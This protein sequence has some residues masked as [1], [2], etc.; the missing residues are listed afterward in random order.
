MFSVLIRVA[1]TAQAANNTLASVA[2]LHVMGSYGSFLIISSV[3][4]RDRRSD[5]RSGFFKICKIC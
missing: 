3:L 4:F 2:Q 1:S 5:E